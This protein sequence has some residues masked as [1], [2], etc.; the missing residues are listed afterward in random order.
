M[1]NNSRT[2]KED[3]TII[4][5]GIREFDKILPGQMIL[6]AVR[7][8]VTAFTPYIAIMMSALILNELVGDKSKTRLMTYVLISIG[9]TLLLSCIGYKIDKKISIGYSRLFSTHEIILTDKAYRIP[10]F[11]LEKESTR[12]L[13]EQVSGSISLSGAGMA[14]LYWDMEVVV[15]NLCSA[16]TALV[17]LMMAD[18][19]YSKPQKE[20]FFVDS[21]FY[22]YHE[23]YHLLR[24]ANEKQILE[25][26]YD[27]YL[28]LKKNNLW[29]SRKYI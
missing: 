25:K 16:G 20:E 24:F 13:R 28:E 12:S 5:R 1:K 21:G 7:S 14:S 6:L 3:I 17:Y 8:T 2:I 11:L 15:K 23:A 18:S 9:A 26:A 4:K 27:E 10:F 22:K 19:Y 29:G